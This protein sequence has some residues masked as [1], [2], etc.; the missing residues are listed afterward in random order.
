M[1]K[2]F[3]RNK[4]KQQQVTSHSDVDFVI[5]KYT[6]DVTSHAITTP[7]PT[8]TP[9][10][11]PNPA[12]TEQR[13]G[14]KIH[15]AQ[16]ALGI[17]K[18][19]DPHLEH[20]LQQIH[21]HH[22]HEIKIPEDSFPMDHRD[23]AEKKERKSFWDGITRDRDR[24]EDKERG[25]DKE[26]ETRE[27]E[28]E[29]EKDKEGRDR[30]WRE[31]D[32][33]SELKRMIGYLTATSSED[34]TL[35]LEVSDRA[36]ATEANAK[37]AVKA[38]RR[39]L[40]YAE[41][42]SQ[43]SAA[44]LWEIMLRNAS[45]IFLTQISS[46][47]FIDTLQGVL[48]SSRTSPVVR[49]R[50]MEVLAAAAFITSSRPCP[51]LKSKPSPFILNGYDF[52]RNSFRALWMRLKPADKPDVGMPFDTE[53]TV[54]SPLAVP[55]RLPVEK[56]PSRK[57]L[58]RR[59]GITPE[60]YMKCLLQECKIAK[61]HATVLSEMLA[62]AKPEQMEWNLIPS[63]TSPLRGI[64][65][66]L[67][68]SIDINLRLTG[69]QEVLTK[70]RRSQELICTQIPWASAGAERSRTKLQ[71]DIQFSSPPSRDYH[72][73]EGKFYNADGEEQ[74]L[75]EQLSAALLD[76]NEALFGV[77]RKYDDV[78][79]V[80]EKWVDVENID[81]EYLGECN[82]DHGNSSSCTPSPTSS[83]LTSPH[84]FDLS[85][86][87]P[88][89]IHPLPRLFVSTS[90]LPA[91]PPPPMGP[92]SPKLSSPA[93]ALDSKSPIRPSAG[94]FGGIV[95][96]V[97]DER[98]LSDSPELRQQ[99]F[100][101]S[102][103]DDAIQKAIHAQ[104]DDAPLRL[105]DTTSGL[106]C[107][108]EAQICAFKLSTKYKELLSSIINHAD[109]QMERIKEVVAFYFRF[110]MLSHRWEGKEP[111]LH[112]IKNK[113]VYELDPAGGIMK[114][115]SFCQTTRGAGYLWAWIDNCCIDQKNNVELQK[116]L[117]SMFDWYRYSALT[118]VYL[119]DVPPSSKS[120]ALARSA[121]NTRGWTVPEFLAPKIVLFYQNDWTLY[122]DDGSPNHKESAT[123]MQE[124][125][126]ATGIDT[127]ALIDFRPGMTGARE[128]LR[129]ASG[130]VT[131]VQEDIAY[132]LFGIFGVHLPILYGEKKQ[133][134]LGR[135]L[136]EI[137][138]QS[139]DITA[140]DWV[141]KSSEFNSCLPADITSYKALP[142]AL[143]LLSEED[144][145]TSVSWLKNA[146]DIDVA[147]KLYNLL[148]N[149]GA[150]RFANRR[151]HLPCIAFTVTQVRRR[152]AQDQEGYFAYEVKADGL[153]RM[154]ITTEDKLTQFSREKP[155]L[156]T[157]LLVRPWHPYLLEL[158]DFADNRHWSMSS[159]SVSDSL[160][161]VSSESG[162]IGLQS[163]SRALRLIVRLGQP[164]SAF[165]LA[166]QRSG[167][168]KRIASD[169]DIIAQVEDVAGSVYKMMD[170]RTL[171]IL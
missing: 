63:A 64:M 156:Q 155:T 117:N 20:A 144:I 34:W 118:M 30:L 170:A 160:S 68:Y 49:N 166:R 89:Q 11:N 152:R 76:A 149:L 22:V 67:P 133:K 138:A 17:L 99:Y 24:D 104:L 153:R 66:L 19:H 162:P 31:E 2:L 137:V 61:G 146:V 48:T 119:S 94:A 10:T 55:T 74:T 113:A 86:V 26:R 167:E 18:Y 112:D 108:R 71:L 101:L 158:P 73:M 98:D 35:V 150:P 121:W 109:I 169:Y 106:L 41:P 28:K 154:V 14:R 37:E 45:D 25:R 129:W 8:P 40:I 4:A 157:L 128:K 105:L 78:M 135:L 27:K 87:T 123:I 75:E 69:P 47:T 147:L 97:N 36:S 159:W 57:G 54:F 50:L 72:G 85:P 90:A 23:R 171:E 100:N 12:H 38:L 43:L 127:Q 110:V 21:P 1:E 7:T 16:P 84:R 134:A 42:K 136:Q 165:L 132:S 6:V 3:E 81:N 140:L 33:P 82:N 122:L 161:V 126:D 65:T 141:G 9:Q 124:L 92:R 120:G 70:C 145:Q 80:T 32:N 116:S 95:E 142:C 91:P 139:G 102:E 125:E 58:H 15:K 79:R 96:E 107:D 44:T 60:E 53:D 148:D 62:Y 93:P 114:L 143:P 88:T 130:R 13:N 164:F 29:R 131:T 51:S 115:Q 77:L 52:D 56:R 111:L 5:D 163:G 103:A 168:Y 46:R 151:L 39:E 59:G 83:P